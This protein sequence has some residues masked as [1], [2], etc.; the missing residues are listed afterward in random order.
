MLV[1]YDGSEGAANAI[2]CAGPLLGPREA[3]VVHA[4]LEFDPPDADEAE[5]LAAEG[6]QS[7]IAS[8]LRAQP[9]AVEERD[10]TWQ[11][12][13]D[14]AREHAAV[15]IV[16][17]A[18]GRS[19][20]ARALLGSV[21][22]GLVHHS[23]IPVLVVPGKADPARMQRPA[24][25]CYD[26]SPGSKRAIEAGG[27]LLAARVAL[28]LHI[29]E[30]WSAHAPTGLPLV[31]G[32]V[33]GMARELDEI[34]KEQSDDLAHA[35][36]EEA[37]GAGFVGQPLSEGSSGVLW[38]RLLDVADEQ[39]AS[40]IVLGSRG[41][42]GLSGVLGSVSYGVIHHAERPVLLVPSGTPNR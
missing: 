26:A 18:R 8:G 17:G 34:A 31:G 41:L 21:S 19:A 5:R 28:V 42:S 1:A 11:A 20:I 2:A 3:L 32:S 13:T 6:A 24:L 29:W 7:A 16:A 40:A 14:C 38:R 4:Y 33:G 39:E 36:V 30:S 37:T 15:A 9:L 22:N 27:E 35:G 10:T 12:L 23:D 25:L